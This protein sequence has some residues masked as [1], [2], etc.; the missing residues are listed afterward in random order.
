VTPRDYATRGFKLVFWSAALGKGPHD[1]GWTTR[2]YPPESYQD[3]MN[4]GVKTGT[5]IEPGKFL[6]DTDLDWTPG[7]PYAGHFLATTGFVFGRKSRDISH[8]FYTTT[9]PVVTKQFKDID[10]VTVF[11]ELRGAKEN[12][13]VGFQTMV[14]PSLHPCGE[15]IEFRGNGVICHDDDAVQRVTHYAVFCAL[16]KHL[17]PRGFGHDTRLAVACFL[18]QC[19]LTEVAVTTLVKALAEATGNSVSD[20]ALTVRTTVAKLNAKEKVKGRKELV[21]LVGRDLVVRLEEWLGVTGAFPLTEAGDAECFADLYKDS[22]RHDHRQGRWLVSDEV[23]G[24]WVPDPVER[25]TQLTVEMMRVRQRQSLALEGDKKAVAMKWALSGEARKRLS[26]TLALARSVPPIAD[27]GEH[28]DEHPFL[29]GTQNGVVDLQTGT[30]RRAT[31]AD[32]VTM[33]VRVAYD[34]S[35]TCPLWL[36]TL[37]GI[38]APTTLF[39]QEESLAMIAFVQ[40]S[41]GYSITGDC[42]EEC[43]FFPWGSGSNGKGTVMNTLGWLFGD[44]TDDMPYSTLEKSERGCGIPN[45]IA[46]LV[47][48]RFITCAEVNE[49]YLN[50]ARLKALTGR[51]PMT[52]RFL[53]HEFFTFIP[54]CKIWLATNNKPRIV[55]QDEGIWRRIHLIPFTQNFQ[56]H[57]DK[58]L[59]DRLRDELPGILNWAIEGVR[60]W[61]RDGL[62]PPDTVKLATAAYRQESNPVTPFVEACCVLGKGLRM[63]AVHAYEAYEEFAHHEKRWQRLTNKAFYAVMG[64]LFQVDPASKRQ[65]FYLDVGLREPTKRDETGDEQFANRDEGDG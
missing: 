27:P 30:F 62:N 40:R 3:G 48:K 41:V 53:N 17:G 47:G 33:R 22:V 31:P 44:Y 29:L 23:S 25:L 13:T 55:G 59:K 26:N 58:T 50:E 7:I 5:E 57:E 35:A 12:G 61:L 10:N 1:T 45:D 28:W 38:F 24:I 18:L 9:T 11:V 42:R 8:A 34:P 64:K 19:G 60:M 46:K 63:Q 39:T 16:L 4:V 51:D 37:A 20:A 56:G 2:D 49:F 21:T 14:P 6:V 54:M 43:C 65:T 15:R 36:Q 32:R 52:A